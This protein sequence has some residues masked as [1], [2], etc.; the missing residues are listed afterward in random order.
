MTHPEDLLAGYVDGALSEQERAVVDAHLSTCDR[1]REE[2]DLAARAS[3]ALSTL[4]IEPVP[5]GVTGPVLAEARKASERRQPIWAR[6]QW[7]V[8]IAAAATLVLIAFVLLPQ[9]TGD[10]DQEEPALRASAE[11]GGTTPAAPAAAAAIPG[12]ER[13][14]QDLDERDLAR[15]ARQTASSQETGSAQDTTVEAPDEAVS[16][17]IASGAGIDDESR[18][19]RLIEATYLG[20]PAYIGVLQE[21]PGGDRPPETVVV[22]VASSADCGILTLL[23]RAI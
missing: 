19:V 20:T 23:S 11:V 21:G 17:L 3:S 4:P 9:V 1:C 16:C 15:L 10:R 22:W 12:L 7:A 18:L 5:F 13:V 14:D 2:V 8:G 6:M